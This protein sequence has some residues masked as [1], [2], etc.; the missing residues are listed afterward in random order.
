ML[1]T[2]KSLAA[3]EAGVALIE[4]GLLASLIAVVAMASVHTLGKNVSTLY[5]NVAGSI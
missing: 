4:Y 2:L 5:G 1:N 3:D